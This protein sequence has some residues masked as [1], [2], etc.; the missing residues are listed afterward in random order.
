M[1]RRSITRRAQA[2]FTLIELMIV[3]A[4]IGILAA[5]AIPQYQTYVAKSQVARVVGE[6]GDQKTAVEDCINNGQLTAGGPTDATTCGGT[7]TG[8]NLVANGAGNTVNGADG[9]AGT[10]APALVIV[11][12][13]GATLTSTF[14]NSAA[15]TLVGSNVV[16][17]RAAADGTW[18]CST[19]VAAKYTSNACPAA[20]AAPA[21]AAGA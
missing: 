12:G 20:A 8:S 15:A 16:W 17:T 6:T 11:A 10:G 14:G 9:P 2:G 5:I 19:T 3:V 7:A 18:T 4:I 13:G 1:N 21:P